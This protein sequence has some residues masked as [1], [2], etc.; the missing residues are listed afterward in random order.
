MRSAP[1]EKD[2]L[3]VTIEPVR[4]DFK[5]YQSLVFKV[6]FRNVSQAV[7]RF[8][9]LAFFRSDDHDMGNATGYFWQLRLQ[10]EATGATYT[11]KPFKPDGYTLEMAEIAPGEEW[12]QTVELPQGRF[13]LDDPA[14]LDADEYIHL[15]PGRSASGLA[16]FPEDGAYKV[17]VII[18][19]PP[20]PADDRWPTPM[21]TGG[22]I[23]TNPVEIT[24]SEK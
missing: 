7:F 10:E 6:T 16:G 20:K 12:V 15:G 3:S 1:A 19:F 5:I 22:S 13:R 4:K 9:Y 18:Q 11:E 14:R 17:S 2:G 23:Q 21:W 8:P 24:I